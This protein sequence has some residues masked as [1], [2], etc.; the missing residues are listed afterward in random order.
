MAKGTWWVIV[1]DEAQAILYSR[2]KKFSPLEQRNTLH[3]P[4]A[5]AKRADLLTDRG[6]RSFDSRGAGRHTMTKETGPRQQ[7]AMAF[8]RLIAE[9]IARA[10][11]EG[12]C[13]EYAIVAAPRFLGMLRTALAGNVKVEPWL[14]IDKA[15]VGR[16]TATIDKLLK[17]HMP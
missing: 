3:N 2:D 15:M 5:R 7:A 16:D 10:L 12:R 17:D 9:R 14:T 1:A 4:D 13:S 8:A 11:Q 6:G